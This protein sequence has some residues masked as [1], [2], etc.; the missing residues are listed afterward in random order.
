MLMKQ[1]TAG[2]I[3][4]QGEQIFEERIRPL[5]EHG[6]KG[7]YVTIDVDTGEW[8]MGDDWTTQGGALR[9]KHPGA[10]LYTRRIGY[11]YVVRIGRT[12]MVTEP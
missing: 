7:K 5:V 3:S 11:P 4:R 6:D 1:G 12:P 2:E 10:L 9:A 8:E